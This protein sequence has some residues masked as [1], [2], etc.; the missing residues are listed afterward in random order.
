MKGDF[1]GVKRGEAKFASRRRH[2]RWQRRKCWCLCF[3]LFASIFLV[4]STCSTLDSTSYVKLAT[5]LTPACDNLSKRKDATGSNG[6]PSLDN[7]DALFAV[8]FVLLSFFLS[9]PAAIERSHLLLLRQTK[10]GRLLPRRPSS[11]MPPASLSLH[12]GSA[13]GGSSSRRRW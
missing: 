11:P 13:V 7:A 5:S 12:G 2:R 3:R 4:T 1:G 10:T 9:S 8:R 6:A